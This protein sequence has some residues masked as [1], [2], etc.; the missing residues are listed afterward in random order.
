MLRNFMSYYDQAL[1][2]VDSGEMTWAKIR[3]AT[4]DEW[5]ALSQVRVEALLLN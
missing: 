4:N 3:E 1:K 5:Y 2:A